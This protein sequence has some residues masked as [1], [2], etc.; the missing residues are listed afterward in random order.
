M[1][2]KAI[3]QRELKDSLKGCSPKLQAKVLKRKVIAAVL[4]PLEM[5]SVYELRGATA[6]PSAPV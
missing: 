4:K 2:A 5:N 6:V 3:K 1:T